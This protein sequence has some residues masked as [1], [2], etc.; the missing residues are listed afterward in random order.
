M[1]LIKKENVLDKFAVR[2][3][4]VVVDT[5]GMGWGFHDYL[6]DAHCTF[7]GVTDDIYE[8]IEQQKKGKI[9]KGG[10]P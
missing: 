5:S 2:E 1:T 3:R 9:R 7:Y 10:R 8:E 6:A 4:K